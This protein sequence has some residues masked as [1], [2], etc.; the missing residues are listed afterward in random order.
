ML[1]KKYSKLADNLVNNTLLLFKKR[2][3]KSTYKTN[4]FIIN[5]FYDPN[6]LTSINTTKNTSYI[7]PPLSRNTYLNVTKHQNI[8]QKQQEHSYNNSLIK[9]NFPFK[10]STTTLNRMNGSGSCIKNNSSI[11][12]FN[13]R[14]KHNNNNNNNINTS[15]DVFMLKDNY[16][17]KYLKMKLDLATL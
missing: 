14:T 2:R 1:A 7:V 6:K 8:T 5:N 10:K 11:N 13:N 3:N 17:S 9:N 4:Q 15:K 12:I 16:N